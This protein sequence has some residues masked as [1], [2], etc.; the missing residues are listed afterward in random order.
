MTRRRKTWTMRKGKIKWV[1]LTEKT[2]H[3]KECLRRLGEY[4]S[5]WVWTYERFCKME[6]ISVGFMWCFFLTVGNL[7]GIQSWFEPK[8]VS[9]KG[10]GSRL[11]GVHDWTLSSPIKRK[12]INSGS[13]LKGTELCQGM[14]RL[15]AHLG[16]SFLNSSSVR[17]ELCSF[18]SNDISKWFLDFTSPLF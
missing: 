18:F 13:Y 7:C 17:R 2:Q 5:Y 12:V 14:N 15:A 1:D 8:L 3:Q 6:K 9:T 4:M 11:P 10:I 16:V